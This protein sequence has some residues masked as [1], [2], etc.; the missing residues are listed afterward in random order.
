MAKG[1]FGWPKDGLVVQRM[2]RTPWS[3]WKPST[4]AAFQLL[5]SKLRQGEGI[6]GTGASLKTFFFP[7]PAASGERGRATRTWP[8]SAPKGSGR[9]GSGKGRMKKCKSALWG[10][11][12]GGTFF[13]S[14][15]L[16]WGAPIWLI[17]S[18]WGIKMMG[19]GGGF[20]LFSALLAHPDNSSLFQEGSE[21]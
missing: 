14:L 17:L 11:K 16:R 3:F 1:W 18:F 8:R 10:I 21:T 4:V 7:L 2:V 15:L 20:A 6:L 19:E 9:E 12:R 5:G 13:L